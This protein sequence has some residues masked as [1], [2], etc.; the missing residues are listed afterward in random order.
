MCY[1]RGGKSK[2]VFTFS[3]MARSPYHTNKYLACNISEV[4]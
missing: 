2:K 4:N 1:G 3:P